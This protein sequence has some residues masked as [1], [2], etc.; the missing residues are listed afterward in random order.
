MAKKERG[1]V[2]G[3]LEIV[4]ILVVCILAGIVFRCVEEVLKSGFTG[5][6]ED[7]HFTLGLAAILSVICIRGVISIWK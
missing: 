7:A 1:I 2:F 6:L 3:L 4:A 5:V